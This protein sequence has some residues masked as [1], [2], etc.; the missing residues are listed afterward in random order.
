MVGVDNHELSDFFGLT[1]IDQNVTGQAEQLVKTMLDLLENPDQ[2][3]ESVIDWPI[4]LVVRG[5]TTRVR[6]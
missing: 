4:E 3:T 6:N 5:S 1:T 2:E